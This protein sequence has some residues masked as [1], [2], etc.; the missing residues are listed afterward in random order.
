MTCA[1]SAEQQSALLKKVYKDIQVI[2]KEKKSF[3]VDAYINNFY[4]TLI[5]K[6]FDQELAMN[7]VQLLPEFLQLS[8]VGERDILN[9]FRSITPKIS[10]D[11]L[12]E[13][14]MDFEEADQ[15]EDFLGLRKPA[16]T[17]GLTPTTTVEIIPE[18]EET[19]EK[20]SDPISEAFDTKPE[21]RSGVFT[22]TTI[23]D[24]PKVVKV[25]HH[26]KVVPQDFD[27]GNFKRGKQ[28]ISQFGDGLNA[29]STTTPFLVQRYG[30]PIE[31]EIDDSN[32]VVIDANK[33]QKEMYEILVSKGFKFNHPQIGKA[34]PQGGKYV[35]GSPA[36]EYDDLLPLKDSPGSATT[37]FNDFQES[38]PEAKG[39]KVINHII[40]NQKVDPFYVI[41][42]AKSFY[43]PGSL[44][45]TQSTQSTDAKADIERR[46]QEDLKN[47]NITVEDR[48]N[49]YYSLVETKGSVISFEER[50][51]LIGKKVNFIVKNP[52]NNKL[53]DNYKGTI[54]KHESAGIT[55]DLRINLELDN[56]QT[57][58]IDRNG[59]YYTQS[60]VRFT[61]EIPNIV[62]EIN[63]KYDAEITQKQAELDALESTQQQALQVYS[64]YLDTGK[65]DIEGFKEFVGKPS[66]S[67]AEFNSLKA[68]EKQK[69]LVDELKTG[70]N[71]S[72]ETLPK[73]S[74]TDSKYLIELSDGR[75]VEFYNKE[76]LLKPDEERVP[77]K[78]V[79]V[80]E[81]KD[82]KGNVYKDVIR[83]VRVKDNK[84]LGSVR[85]TDEF[86]PTPKVESVESV[87]AG[88]AATASTKVEREVTPS[89]K[90][91]ASAVTLLSDRDP[92]VL[93]TDKNSPNYNIED[94]SKEFYVTVKLQLMKFL[95]S[96][97]A[98][99]GS[100]IN[101]PG[102]GPVFFTAMSMA[103]LKTLVEPSQLRQ[104]EMSDNSIVL[105]V[106]DEKGNLVKF[107]E[108]GFADASGKIAYYPMRS[109]D[110]FYSN[111]KYNPNAYAKD[112]KAFI[113]SIRTKRGLSEEEA[114]AI[115]LNEISLTK[116]ISDYL[117]TN[118]STV[119][120]DLGIG[121]FGFLGFDYEIKSPLSSI[122]FGNKPFSF[123][124]QTINDTITGR[125][126]NTAYF[127]HENLGEKYIAL[128][129]NPLSKDIVERILTL[130]FDEIEYKTASGKSITMDAGMKN[131]L[132][133]DLIFSDNTRYFQYALTPDNNIVF[134]LGNKVL[135]NTPQDREA[136]RKYLETPTPSRLLTADQ[137][138]NFKKEKLDSAFKGEG[139]TF[140]VED[141]GSL[142]KDPKGNYWVIERPK[143]NIVNR[144][145]SSFK[146]IDTITKKDDKTI[147]SFKDMSYNDF[148]K[149]N[150]YVHFPL[151][152]RK[153]L[154]SV[155][156]YF[157]FNVNYN[158]LPEDLKM[159]L[160]PNISITPSIEDG[161]TGNEK[162]LNPFTTDED[163]LFRLKD[164]SEQAVKA[165]LKQIEEA[166]VWY[167]NHPLRKFLPDYTVMFN[168]INA[169]NHKAV[170]SWQVQGIV[171]YKGSDYTDLYHE[172]WH[173]F[174]Q[175]FLTKEEKQNLYNEVK[176]LLGS[177]T[178][179]EGKRVT[180][181]D[182]NAKQLEEYLAEDFR[183]YM[184][185]PQ[186]K[187]DAPV[188]NTIFQKI[189]NFLKALY[190][191]ITLKELTSTNEVTGTLNEIYENLRVGNISTVNFSINNVDHSILNKTLIALDE[192]GTIS[193]LVRNYSD[194]KEISD[195]V[196]ALISEFID[197]ANHKKGNNIS[198]NKILSDKKGILSAYRY[199][200]NKIG[201]IV[202]GLEKKLSETENEAVKQEIQYK[203]DLYKWAHTNF[204]NLEDL[205]A[206]RP[207]GLEIKGV[208]AYHMSKS[209]I[210]STG[211][212]EDF[213]EGDS[214][215][216]AALNSR[217]GYSHKAGN[218]K[219]LEELADPAIIA[220][221]KSLMKTDNRGKVLYVPG[222]EVELEHNGVKFTTGIP[223]LYDFDRAW[224]V[225]AK[226][227]SG[228]RTIEDMISK[229]KDY[230]N[231]HPQFPIQQILN[232][233][234]ENPSNSSEEFNLWANFRQVFSMTRVPLLQTTVE[235]KTVDS[236]G[237]QLDDY[238]FVVKPGI[239]RSN[240]K[241]VKE[242]WN[243][244]FKNTTSNSFIKQDE[245]KQNYLDI[246][247]LLK[248][249]TKESANNNPFEFLKAIGF[250]LDDIYEIRKELSEGAV[251]VQFIYN[252]LVNLSKRD[253]KI[254]S[255]SDL[256]KAYPEI[257][258]G[259]E[260]IYAV[261]ENVGVFNDI[262]SLQEKH[263]DEW[264]NFMVSNAK[265]DMQ[266]EHTLNST[267]SVMIQSIN[268]VDTYDQLIS[269]PWM[270]YLDSK[271]NPFVKASKFLNSIFIMD[272][273][274]AD[275]GK[276]RLD[277]KNP[278]KKITINLQ[279]LSGIAI[280]KDNEGFDP[281]AAAA[282]AEA[283]GSSKLIMD[284]HML[285]LKGSP[286]FMRHADKATSFT[287]YLSNI[288]K[289]GK[290]SN[291]YIDTV[292]FIDI[293]NQPNRGHDAVFVDHILPYLSAETER[294]KIAREKLKDYKDGKEVIDDFS[295]LERGNKFVMFETILKP[296]TKLEIIKVMNKDLNLL[297]YLNS[298]SDEAAK[299]RQTIYNDVYNYFQSEV[300]DVS[301]QFAKTN[302]AISDNLMES[303]KKAIKADPSIMAGK[304]ITDK[305][306]IVPKNSKQLISIDEKGEVSIKDG[307]TV[308]E[309]INF[310]QGRTEL[311]ELDGKRG[312]IFKDPSIQSLLG[313]NNKTFFNQFS[314]STSIH[315]FLVLYARQVKALKDKNLTD[316]QSYQEL[317]NI[318]KNLLTRS[319]ESKTKVIKDAIV[320]SF[321]YNS[322]IHHFETTIMFYG[323][324]ALYNLDKLEFHKRIPGISSTGTTYA[325]GE[326]AIT[327]ANKI[328][329]PLEYLNNGKVRGYDE[330]LNTV[331]FDDHKPASRYY[332]E[333]LKV[334]YEELLEENADKLNK[335]SDSERV[336][337][338]EKLMEKAKSALNPYSK[339]EMKE[340]DAQGWINPDT[341]RML[342]TLEGKW[343]DKQENLYQ[344]IISNREVKASEIV[345]TF[346]PLK[347]QYWGPI[348]TD[349]LNKIAFHKF[350]LVPLMPNVVKDKTVQKLLNSMLDKGIDYAL[351]A[352]GSKVSTLTRNKVT[353]KFYEND[354]RDVNFDKDFTINKVF[355]HYLKNQL[356]IA[357]KFK[358]KV[359]FSTQLRKLIEIG[360]VENGVPTD[361]KPK[362]SLKERIKS[363]E[364]E[365]DKSISKNYV[366]YTAYENKIKR[367]TD[368]KKR[369]LL[370]EMSWTID[371]YTKKPKGNLLDLISF[372]KKEL[373]NQELADHELDFI[374][375]TSDGNL[376][377]DLSL[378]AAAD[379]IERLLNAMVTKRLVK[380]KINGEALIQVATTGFEKPTEEQ[381]NEYGNDLPFYEAEYDDE[382]NR[383]STK[384]MKVK[385]ALQGKF[386]SL[387][388]LTHPDGKP[389]ENL[390]RLN[391]LLQDE[392]WLNEGNNR[393][394]I[395]MVG[396][397]IPVQGLN[398]MEFMEVYEFL[399]ES[400]GQILIPPTEIVAK[401]GSDF[402]IDKMTVFMPTIEII[403]GVAE[404]ITDV[405]EDMSITELNK[406]IDK[407]KTKKREI[408]EEYADERLLL[409]GIEAF[410]L[411]P[412]E[413]QIISERTSEL[414]ETKKELG[415]EIKDLTNL[416]TQY[417]IEKNKGNLYVSRE[418]NELEEKIINLDNELEAVEYS[419][420]SLM[421]SY[422][423]FMVQE[424]FKSFYER[425]EKDLEP[426][427]KKLGE[428]KLRYYRAKGKGIENGII[429]DIKNIL[430]KPD[431]F[432][433]LVRPNDT[434]IVKPI[435]DD[436]S[437]KV[438]DYE[439]LKNSNLQE[440][441]ELSPE[442]IE[443]LGGLRKKGTPGSK[444]FEILYN[445]HQHQVNNI[446]KKVLGIGAVDN[447]YNAIFNRIGFRLNA[448]KGRPSEELYQ[449]ALNKKKEIEERNKKVKYESKKEAVPKKVRD[450]IKKY[451]TAER[452]SI[453]MNHN[454]VLDEKGQEVISLSNLY[455]AE[456]NNMI[457][458][459]I[460]QLINGW[461]D[462]AKDPWIF[463]VQ[464]N[465]EI[466]PTLLFL[467]QSGV[468]FE[469]AAYFVSQP[470][471]RDYVEYQR[472]G[473]SSFNRLMGADIESVNFYKMYAKQQ[474]FE[475]S[476]YG[477]PMSKS[478]VPLDEHIEAVRKKFFNENPEMEFDLNG[479]SN[480]LNNQS[481]VSKEGKKI[482]YSDFDRGVLLHFLQLEEMA[483]DVSMIKMKTNFDTSRSNTMYEIH[484]R[485][486]GVKE[487]KQS[488]FYKPEF[489][490]SILK[491]TPIGSFYVQEFQSEI[492][493]PLFNL[494]NDEILM[495]YIKDEMIENKKFY[496]EYASKAFGDTEY[497]INNFRNQFQDYIF[498]NELKRNT[499]DSGYYKGLNVVEDE[500]LA[501]KKIPFLSMGAYVVD[502]VLYVSKSNIK[503][504]YI[505]S[506]YLKTKAKNKPEKHYQSLGL[507]PVESRYF[508]SY[509]EYENFVIERERLRYYYKNINNIKETIEFLRIEKE[510]ASELSGNTKEK[511]NQILFEE[512]LKQKA[513]ENTF[514]MGYLF[515]S[516]STTG[517]KFNN[518]LTKYPDLVNKYSVLQKIK[519][520][521][522]MSTDKK[523]YTNLRLTENLT[524][525][526]K[527]NDYHEQ[528]SKLINPSVQK[529][530]DDKA[531]A[532]ISEFF[533]K[534]SLIAY[535][536][537]GSNT[538][539]PFSLT[540]IMPNY[541]YMIIMKEGVKKFQENN[542]LT[543]I[544]SYNQIF[545][546]QNRINKNVRNRGGRNYFNP[547]YL[548]AEQ[549]LKFENLE[550]AD[551]NEILSLNEQGLLT[552]DLNQPKLKGLSLPD[553]DN[554]MKQNHNVLFV[555]NKSKDNKNLKEDGKFDVLTASN[556]LGIVTRERWYPGPD[557]EKSMHL[558]DTIV[559]NQ[560]GRITQTLNLENKELVDQ[561]IEKLLSLQ[562]EGYTLAFNKNGYGLNLI[563][564]WEK[565]KLKDQYYAPKTYT[566]LSDQLFKNF[567]YVNPINL[568][569]VKESFMSRYSEVTDKMVEDLIK[570]C[571]T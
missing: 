398:S 214:E 282:S 37:L 228:T 83:V 517:H 82:N 17:E 315:N 544:D 429:E 543:E 289:T 2:V 96:F 247:A 381:Q 21:E 201:R 327:Y 352:S 60:N 531:N 88:S 470:I 468:P 571:Y 534:L 77:V 173:A 204:G 190:E 23:E 38:N 561:F 382:G 336:K 87:V 39:V 221:F 406:E 94:K 360:L 297:D 527:I 379:K 302:N 119:K 240:L 66:T 11:Y 423:S 135:K 234:G 124:V 28:Q 330:K 365:K 541:H 412:E 46:R 130:V 196:D 433:N 205:E 287:A 168:A 158:Y 452:V 113:D 209:K 296:K 31:G 326:H 134:K 92:N 500:T 20:E 200:Y 75:I 100:E 554:F 353:D 516:N 494:R 545:F 162:D 480:N 194:S 52:N 478:N 521:S 407:L 110:K 532:E 344:K 71:I 487:L 284:L 35:G 216:D 292:D 24:K 6:G 237:A 211:I 463:F 415:K 45:K 15:I 232:K 64:Q 10:L 138:A 283:D 248:A 151:N 376:T 473:R 567:G 361:Y 435:A 142:Y 460:S 309:F 268:E 171:L 239:A 127:Q 177:F 172:A 445:L 27:F 250:E 555:Y 254:T 165:T 256:E 294:I 32:F 483:N 242:Y 499:I 103:K 548:N 322:W 265:G 411:S 170:A 441:K 426:I 417:S 324:V 61:E 317:L 536:Q 115:Y 355:V 219:S 391:S 233:L 93:S 203:I 469:T 303:V 34:T 444:V 210:L 448:Y 546:N 164:Q 350:S 120:L 59:N 251:K 235:I 351:F 186:P 189:L 347:L 269:L 286:E 477:L 129:R 241:K 253:I 484:N 513:L 178:D 450:I 332:D 54:I 346:P 50:N 143:I 176:K 427:F 139:N 262:A 349:G 566:Y 562:S 436:L 72:G 273:D 520:S 509:L 453:R 184:L 337:E 533:R 320:K 405:A 369:E 156:P 264:A 359:I 358:E 275:Y 549:N 51:S 181:K 515:T 223:Q 101:Y 222:T 65:Q 238:S 503:N 439:P 261:Q 394:M 440:E 73:S 12:T 128:E 153:E 318:T 404:Y 274:S 55:G 185:N 464:G 8:V 479:L 144:S 314:D 137:V 354:N 43:G 198:T 537:S 57:F 372:V 466:S 451:E 438:M 300:S 40:G 266:Y 145:T 125:K 48:G 525:S 419:I 323:D 403:N 207:R 432:I 504:Q 68:S 556:K 342:L 91:S 310:L 260:I 357:P 148:I 47:N 375:I 41:Y 540:R 535:L 62:L 413:K 227:L 231:K 378:S 401:S 278:E 514:N 276:K 255:L 13:L 293:P 312:L 443:L 306:K 188:R 505:E 564:R 362:L 107:R 25:Y 547:F 109:V 263:S 22:L 321:V 329:R 363:W 160:Y 108:D 174:T 267:L 279:N 106:S 465:K 285:L 229:M 385:I 526:D 280:E 163:F 42:D 49:N 498:Q 442:E 345:D 485:I 259:K 80:P 523:T 557:G 476:D 457:A 380:Q 195:A 482:E 252:V 225:T 99:N 246:R 301:K 218:E 5:D 166:K 408:F 213:F 193:S 389:I 495:E 539:T 553:V 370:D 236:T 95:K 98:E 123:K 149:N 147:V 338:E 152:G 154:F 56:G 467:V 1:L 212:K 33:S 507:S 104:D 550:L 568:N 364:S 501:V 79:Y 493:K 390:Q 4:S 277:P 90:F 402:D 348:D 481:K 392:T 519:P 30:N 141:E 422:K 102:V 308:I 146:Y 570:L 243:S 368:I 183:K 150:T 414:I 215:E 199:A 425:K 374:D 458:D 367:L 86:I 44:S 428:L 410:A 281:D 85:I 434:S 552:F 16:D 430:S 421:K 395:T 295:Y 461:V 53:I 307:I 489:I 522:V 192:T 7:Y 331:I 114:K 19:V 74:F 226:I 249:F 416:W 384:A 356:E 224:N 291:L 471:I 528:M 136:L 288:N 551:E 459:V 298:T 542:S 373:T 474:L 488:E 258:N 161:I 486:Y 333:Y 36:S 208:I 388:T 529:V 377:N 565:G 530:Q 396:V 339:G 371:P 202:E 492:W 272:P 393:K 313:K 299:L 197:L 3:N 182:A 316:S 387:L 126:A 9:Y 81:I 70:K 424:K 334:Y 386:K 230:S 455:D 437:D 524:D 58:S 175:T 512:F 328:G 18:K 343:S 472:R 169:A 511:N 167:D 257:Q 179:Y 117:L 111:G 305:V 84:I 271:R 454:K 569:T 157:S 319:K 383:I 508:N 418:M 325:T 400:A 399:D 191:G 67:T 122:N 180:F 447:T 563:G 121:S 366:I 140:T 456:N 89:D 133:S 118:N 97:D 449:E 159:F 502:E 187:K 131:T 304:K 510:M 538:R 420:H 116:T 506:L 490:D 446:G 78:L 270:N 335:L 491:E 311:D 560:D 132:L 26:T 155:N 340:G 14:M 245:F 409:E 559:E 462:V 475:N 112:Q 431:N 518:I 217:D 244:N 220:L 206:N 105:V 29:S 496:K 76:T 558:Y 397:R 497:Y 63:A 69:T 290:D 341:Y